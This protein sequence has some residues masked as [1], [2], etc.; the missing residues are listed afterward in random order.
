M[1]LLLLGATQPAAVVLEVAAPFTLTNT[2]ISGV[3]H[4]GTKTTAQ[5]TFH[6]A[7]GGAVSL[8]GTN[9]SR[10]D[11]SGQSS[12]TIPAGVSTTVLGVTPQVLDNL[13]SAT[14]N[15]P[16][17][18]YTLSVQGLYLQAVQHD[19]HVD[20]AWNDTHNNETGWYVERRIVT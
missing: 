10:F 13:L 3:A 7:S 2:T 12:I 15:T 17:G 16:D 8:A 6:S 14:L 9:A 11:L 5:L 1:P 18:N 19:T 4:A 20:L